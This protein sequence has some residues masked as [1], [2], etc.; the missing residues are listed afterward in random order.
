M[1]RLCLVFVILCVGAFVVAAPIPRAPAPDALGNGYM[2]IRM[3]TDD[4]LVITSVT[5][6]FPAEKAG[7]KAGDLILKI[8]EKAL[9]QFSELGDTIYDCRPGTTVSVVVKRDGAEV[10]LAMLLADI[11]DTP[12]ETGTVRGDIQARRRA[13]EAGNP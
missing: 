3:S 10:T 4:T 5:P 6:G 13:R 8:G 7:L 9:K 1:V 12:T 11:P 2:G